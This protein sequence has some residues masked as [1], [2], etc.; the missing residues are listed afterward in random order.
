MTNT[1][2]TLQLSR[3]S[4]EALADQIVRAVAA[5]IEERLL[6]PGARMPSIRQFA[7]AHGVSPF[8]VVASYDR[9][10]AQGYLDSRRG[11]GFFVRERAQPRGPSTAPA[12]PAPAPTLDIAWLVRS[13]FRQAPLQH[14]PGAGVLPADWLDGPAVAKAMAAL[15]R[16]NSAAFLGYGAPQGFLPL[17]QQLQLKLAEFEIEAA[18]EQIVTTLG[19]TQA[20]DL[21]AREFCRP[22]DT[23]LVDDPAWFLM[24]GSF[25]AMGLNVVGVRRLADGP[26]LE[27]LAEL[28]ARYHPCLYVINS[29]L[30]NP[31]S[32][33]LSAAKAF[34]VLRLAE[35]HGFTVVE[36]DIYADLHPGAGAQPVTRLAALDGLRQVIYLGGFSKSMAPNLRV[37]FIAASG[38][39]AGRLAD[40]KM[41]ATL[42]TS[43]IGERV[44]YKILSEGLYR[45]HLDRVR[46]RLDAARPKVLRQL[47]MLGLRPE[48][49]P[50]AGMFVWVD[51]GRDTNELAARAMQDELLLAPGSLFSPQQLPSTRMRLNVAALQ[52]AGTIRLLERALAA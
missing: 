38:E 44:V 36:D 51:T 35:Q 46:G 1:P 47:E 29:V 7:A 15:S 22:G 12:I 17:R 28:A 18:P 8:T 31:T 30:H 43:D 34:Q 41:L 20:L 40:R 23:I 42:S 25:S 10:V 16:Q 45:K 27:Q 3:D 19:V 33:S 13:M 5:R 11:A 48:P 4:G 50:S 49:A 39:R 14:S 9:L 52:D 24:F 26:D 21:V 6:R 2:T 37:G 32:T